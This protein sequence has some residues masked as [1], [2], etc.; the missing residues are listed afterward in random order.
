MTTALPCT[1]DVI[2]TF[3]SVS[4]RLKIFG[5]ARMFVLTASAAVIP[6]PALILT[7]DSR[8]WMSKVTNTAPR[9][10]QPPRDSLPDAPRGSHTPRCQGARLVSP[11]PR[12]TEAV[13]L[14]SATTKKMVLNAHLGA[15]VF[16]MCWS[17][18]LT[19][20]N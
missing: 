4:H 15:S 18:T 2:L 14:T 17:V 7:H 12:D 6:V 16:L 3:K 5:R 19:S 8:L 11:S 9:C 13:E 1:Q 20:V 10:Y